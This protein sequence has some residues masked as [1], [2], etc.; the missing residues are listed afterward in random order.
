MTDIQ[1]LTESPLFGYDHVQMYDRECLPL[2]N[3]CMELLRKITKAGHESRLLGSTFDRDDFLEEMALEVLGETEY[4]Q[5]ALSDMSRLFG[6]LHDI[7][8]ETAAEMRGVASSLP[9]EL[10]DQYLATGSLAVLR[11]CD[12][13]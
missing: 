2:V 12:G 13:E 10:S 7:T 5:R 4:P 8:L 9:D 11:E 6:Q 1:K 3:L